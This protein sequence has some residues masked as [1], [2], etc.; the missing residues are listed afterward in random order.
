MVL[1]CINILIV[2]VGLPWG[3][4]WKFFECIAT[5]F[6]FINLS[7]QLS[8]HCPECGLDIPW[9][10]NIPIFTWLLQNGMANVAHIKFRIML[11]DS[12]FQNGIL[13][14]YFE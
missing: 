2:M 8:S 4:I 1:N 10:R 11:L 3:C 6:Q 13:F 7:F 5:E 12:E 14:G 9:Y